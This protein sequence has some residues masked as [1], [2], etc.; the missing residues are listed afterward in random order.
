MRA[1]AVGKLYRGVVAT[2]IPDMQKHT[3]AIDE[4]L[5][6]FHNQTCPASGGEV[7]CNCFRNTM[8]GE[9]MDEL[10]DLRRKGGDYELMLRALI[11][12]SGIYGGPKAPNRQFILAIA[13]DLRVPA[14]S[15]GLPEL[16]PEARQWLLRATDR[17]DS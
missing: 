14:G 4:V 2:T 6:R 12:C 9:A 17:S 7:E 15:D 13:N 3:G 8:L 11:P 10:E 5:S 1:N 16:T